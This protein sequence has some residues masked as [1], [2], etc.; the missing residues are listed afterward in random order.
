M[1]KRPNKILKCLETGRPIKGQIFQKAKKSADPCLQGG[2]RPEKDQYG[3]TFSQRLT[4]KI[5]QHRSENGLLGSPGH[6]F[7]PQCVTLKITPAQVKK[8]A[9]SARQAML[10]RCF[11]G[12]VLGS[13][14]GQKSRCVSKPSPGAK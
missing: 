11:G 9:P 1:E 3:K 14:D 7:R 6:R 4:L 8:W 12:C 2:A 5:L 13:L 10:F